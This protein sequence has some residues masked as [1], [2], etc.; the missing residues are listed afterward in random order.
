MSTPSNSCNNAGDVDKNDSE[1]TKSLSSKSRFAGYTKSVDMWALGCVTV[2]LLSGSPPFLD[3]SIEGCDQGPAMRLS[4]ASLERGLETLGIGTFAKDFIRKLL[5]LEEGGR[6]N[7]KQ[8]LYHA[9]F[10]DGARQQEIERRYREAVKHW[11]RRTPKQALIEV[12]D[13]DDPR[14]SANSVKSS[15]KKVRKNVQIPVDPPYIP[16]PRRLSQTLFPKRDPRLPP[17]AEE[18]QA[19]IESDW[20][21]TDGII[22]S[23]SRT[24]SSLPP[25]SKKFT[26][27]HRGTLVSPNRN[28]KVPK[29]DPTS[30]NIG[31]GTPALEDDKIR[32]PPFKASVPAKPAVV[33]TVSAPPKGFSIFK[34]PRTT[35]SFY[36]KLDSTIGVLRESRSKSNIRRPFS[37][38][39]WN[40]IGSLPSAR[41]SPSDG[42]G[43][44]T[45][46]DRGE[47]RTSSFFAEF[48]TDAQTDKDMATSLSQNLNIIQAAREVARDPGLEASEAPEDGCLEGTIA[49]VPMDPRDPG[50]TRSGSPILGSF[51][52][53]TPPSVLLANSSAKLRPL[54]SKCR[55][56][57]SARNPKK[58]SRGSIFD[59]EDDEVSS[60]RAAPV[61]VKVLDH[62]QP[63]KRRLAIQRQPV[64]EE[65]VVNETEDELDGDDSREE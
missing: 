11:K 43:A 36:S 49:D 32:T 53:D 3:R 1:M 62:Q 23:K 37:P 21:S 14:D 46:R 58:R 12:L 22:K 59:F 25:M 56:G 13:T 34:D 42:P 55:L 27:S 64:A 47:M 57:V 41:V 2:F 26:L 4:L 18:V 51:S 63:S 61:T 9:W 16:F 24:S 30:K 33:A 19:A 50:H 65:A 8:A 60:E 15:T 7:V 40:R 38:T 20:P 39:A 31:K 35:T 17:I 5:V 44:K 52:P 45:V 48:S 54:H 6:L 10:T 29:L 28:G